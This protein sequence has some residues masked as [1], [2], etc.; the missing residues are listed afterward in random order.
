M[1][2]EVGGLE[3]VVIAIVALIVVGPK[4]LPIMLRK[5]GQWVGKLRSMANEFRASFDEMA[6]QSELD[7]LRREVEAMRKG[8]FADQAAHEAMNAQT[9]QIFNEIGD[10]LNGSGVQFHPPTSGYQAEG[11]AQTTTIEVGQG[12]AEP[13]VAE[14]A[15]RRRRPAREPTVVDPKAPKPRAKAGAK[16]AAKPAAK[17]VAKKPLAPKAAAAKPAAPKTTRRAAKPK[18]GS[19]A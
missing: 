2:P 9:S 1:L 8:Q 10:S 4:D 6:R 19:V 17:P 13:T 18:A 11:L 12:A 7:E 5:V 14:K 16:P 3:Y 15:P